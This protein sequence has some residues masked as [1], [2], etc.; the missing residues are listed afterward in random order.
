M[1][2]TTLTTPQAAAP[3]GDLTIDK[4]CCAGES[5]EGSREGFEAVHALLRWFEEA[6]LYRHREYGQEPSIEDVGHLRGLLEPFTQSM[7]S[8]ATNGHE[9]L[10]EVLQAMGVATEPAER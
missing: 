1:A 10:T 4:L 7:A 2:K 8:Y 6:A 5:L 3:L 9:Y